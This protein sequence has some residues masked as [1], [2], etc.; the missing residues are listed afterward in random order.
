ME[1]VVVK[2]PREL[3]MVLDRKLQKP[4]AAQQH[5][6]LILRLFSAFFNVGQLALNHHEQID[7]AHL[8]EGED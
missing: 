5:E 4:R 8:T 2:S 1:Q 6:A 7:E 3:C